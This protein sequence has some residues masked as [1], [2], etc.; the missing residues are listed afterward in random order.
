MTTT[1]DSRTIGPANDA[2]W[3]WAWLTG[4]VLLAILFV[5]SGLLKLAFHAPIAG[6]IASK[7]LPAADALAWGV[8]VFEIVAAGMLVFGV[9]LVETTVALAAWCLVTGLMFH[10]FW[11]VQ[12][13]MAQQA[14]LFNFLKNLALVGGLLIVARTAAINAKRKR[15]DVRR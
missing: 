5:V 4:R 6:A 14:E 11:A 12:D 13:P 1:T 15:Q 7:G 2:T 10:Q 9:R 3:H 8:A